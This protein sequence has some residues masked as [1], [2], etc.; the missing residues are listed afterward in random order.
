VALDREHLGDDSADDRRRVA[1]ARPHIEHSVAGPGLDR[2]G[3][4]RHHVWLR[5]GLPGGD[6]QRRVGIGVL[7]QMLVDEDMARH[8]AHR[9]EDGWIG[10][11]APADLPLDH[12]LAQRSL[13]LL[14]SDRIR[15]VHVVSPSSRRFAHGD[16]HPW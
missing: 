3:H 11:A 2:F 14:L 16:A 6:R 1:G 10:D 4:Q 12:E 8:L 7:D 5:D 9:V 15:L 13:V